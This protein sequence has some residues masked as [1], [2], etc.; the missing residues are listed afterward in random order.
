M[1]EFKLALTHYANLNGRST[2]REYWM[3]VLFYILIL[4][5]LYVIQSLIGSNLI[6]LVI[7][8][9]QLAMLIPSLAVLI[10]RLHDVNKSGWFALLCFIPIIN[11]YI[12]YL[13]IQPSHPQSTQWG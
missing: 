5:G 11:L 7:F 8:I 9:F 6:Q 4:I 3:F 10:R 13:L 2:R 12:L 1:N